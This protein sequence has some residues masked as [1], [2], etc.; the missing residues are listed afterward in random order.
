[1][2]FVTLPPS[3]NWTPGLISNSLSGQRLESGIWGSSINGR[4]L[5]W[6]KTHKRTVTHKVPWYRA[7]S[8]VLMGTKLAAIFPVVTEIAL[9]GKTLLSRVTQGKGVVVGTAVFITVLP[10]VTI[11]KALETSGIC[12]GRGDANLF[13]SGENLCWRWK[14]SCTVGK[15]NRLSAFSGDRD[16]GFILVIVIVGGYH[17]GGLRKRGGGD[18]RGKWWG[19][20]GNGRWRLKSTRSAK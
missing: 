16:S 17:S 4:Q 7:N 1:M 15:V 11:A 18:L 19:G 8:T 9:E 10:I 13:Q 6:G 3:Y 2:K 5:G 12:S 20:N 14:D